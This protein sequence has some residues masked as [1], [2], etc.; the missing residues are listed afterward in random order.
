MNHNT[1]RSAAWDRGPGPGDSDVACALRR[2]GFSLVEL[3]IVVAILALLAT[4]I[5]P[6]LSRA[7]ERARGTVC[8]SNLRSIGELL[9]SFANSSDDCPA[10]TLWRLDTF[11]DCEPPLGWDIQTGVVLGVPGGPKSVWVCPGGQRIYMGNAR[12]LGLTGDSLF[13][14]ARFTGCAGPVGRTRPG[15]FWRTTFRPTWTRAGRRPLILVWETS[16]TSSKHGPC[17]S[18]STSRCGSGSSDRTPVRTQR[19]SLTVTW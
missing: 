3:L 6:F 13:Q 19:C 5:A 11:W 8:L 9:H 17:L 16:R 4:I 1:G 7:R 18:R 2:S 12:A 14:T 10:P 15:W